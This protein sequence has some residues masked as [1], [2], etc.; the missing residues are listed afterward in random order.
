LRVSL[1]LSVLWVIVFVLLL[2][3]VLNGL[4]FRPLLRVMQER[5]RAVESA[6]DLAA[7]AAADASAAAQQYE[8]RTQAAR[9]EVHREMDEVRR[10]AEA[11]RAAL[12]AAT[13]QDAETQLAQAK[14]SLAADVDAARAR[15][16]AEADELGRI[17]A[18]RVLGRRAS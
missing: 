10:Q 14:G 7:R 12:L 13:R 16:G 1:D 5:E 11:Q 6:R 8:L 4:I 3:A 9:A 18:D 15:L 2:V 17:I